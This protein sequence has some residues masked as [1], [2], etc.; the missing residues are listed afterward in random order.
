M[1]FHIKTIVSIIDSYDI[2]W[3]VVFGNH[4]RE[5]GNNLYYQAEQFME[6]ENC[7]FEVGPSNV[8]GLGNYVINVTENGHAVYSLFMIDSQSEIVTDTEKYFDNIHKNQIQ[9]YKD[10]VDAISE[11]EG[12]QVPAVNGGSNLRQDTVQSA[13]IGEGDDVL[14][15]SAQQIV[16]GSSE[17]GVNGVNNRGLLL[18]VAG[19]VAANQELRR[20]LIERLPIPI[21]FPAP[22]LCT[23]NAAMVASLGYFKAQR[24]T[25]TDPRHLE[26]IPSISMNQTIWNN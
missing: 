26:V 15:L 16:D 2:P 19:G 1:H 18:L 7:L 21:N 8:D 13:V 6:A 23:D 9:W 14:L 22:T 3:A 24:T 17:R 11:I 20:Q 5:F 12:H 4:D 10:N 25:P